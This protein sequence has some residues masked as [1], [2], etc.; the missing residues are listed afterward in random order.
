MK[1]ALSEADLQALIAEVGLECLDPNGLNSALNCIFF[2]P[3]HWHGTYPTKAKKL[4][5]NQS[6]YKKTDQMHKDAE[7]GV[8]WAITLLKKYKSRIVE[9]Y[10]CFSSDDIMKAETLLYLLLQSFSEEQEQM[11]K[12]MLSERQSI[13]QDPDR[14]PQPTSILIGFLIPNLYRIYFGRE[15]GVSRPSDGGEPYGPAIRFTQG[16]LKRLKLNKSAEAICMIIRRHKT[17]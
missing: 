11:M 14:P 7:Q 10:D 4:R 8:L 2:D 1:A 12:C 17:Q 9:Q 5:D 15:W 3:D 6:I 16:I 13:E